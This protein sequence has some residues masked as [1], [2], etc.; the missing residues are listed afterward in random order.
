MSAAWM[1]GM[2]L[3]ATAGW[4]IPPVE[5]IASYSVHTRLDPVSLKAGTVAAS[6]ATIRSVPGSMAVET[7]FYVPAPPARVASGLMSWNPT[8]S[9]ELGITLHQ[10]EG[11]PLGAADFSVLNLVATKP[12]QRWILDR[13]LPF[14]ADR[15]P[16]FLT[17]AEVRRASALEVGG[18]VKAVNT[19]WREVLATR[20]TG[21]QNAGLSGWVLALRNG[22]EFKP[23]AEWGRVL[24]EIPKV[25]ERFGGLVAA[26]QSGNF[27]PVETS[28]YW[29]LIKVSTGSV[30]DLGVTA[31]Q[32]R[33]GGEQ[34]ADFQYYASTSYFGAL[35]LYDI[36]PHE[37]GSLVWRGDYVLSPDM[38][39]ARGIE[40]V[41]TENI[42]L[43]E[44]KKSIRAFLGSLR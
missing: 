32:S 24:R 34:V 14:S 27:G 20:A 2:I 13:T 21:Y 19:F 41:A 31:R 3:S 17:E 8:T 7:V 42:L 35:V 43:Q 11:R 16:F 38:L 18:G 40:R 37:E 28:H 4:A 23:A 33:S 6:R 29:E 22:G 9:R 12:E 36:L 39:A 15:S 44:V 1:A 5:Q 10:R 26:L 25:R 30:L